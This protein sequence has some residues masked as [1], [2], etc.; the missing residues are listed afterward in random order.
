[1]NEEEQRASDRGLTRL[2]RETLV[3]LMAPAEAQLEWC[4]STGFPSEELY[5]DLCDTVWRA[6]LLV[7]RGV[8]SPATAEL[9]EAVEARFEAGIAAH[10]IDLFED[11]SLHDWDEW[12]Q[13]RGMARIALVALEKGEA[14]R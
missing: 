11:Q 1:M 10:D 8:V 13:I 9:I 3:L 6:S 14:G 12:A 7:E 5:R 4:A 2:V